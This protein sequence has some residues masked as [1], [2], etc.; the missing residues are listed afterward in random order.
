M[1]WLEFKNQIDKE[2]EDRGIDHS[3]IV[4]NYIDV[5]GIQ[6]YLNKGV[7]VDVDSHDDGR[8][9]LAVFN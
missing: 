6:I 8:I 7:S 2:L 3:E 1:T 4:I 5:S 9:T